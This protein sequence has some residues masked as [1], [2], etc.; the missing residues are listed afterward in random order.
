MKKAMITMA[1]GVLLIFPAGQ[2][3]AQDGVFSDTPVCS[4]LINETGYAVYGAVETDRAIGPD[5]ETIYHRSNFRLKADER[6]RICANGPFFPG[7]KVILTLRSLFPL[8]ECKTALGQPIT[9]NATRKD[10]GGYD[11]SATCY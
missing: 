9:I 3:A 1:A 11:W 7:G 4:D 10:S 2:P 5:G 8:F 6:T